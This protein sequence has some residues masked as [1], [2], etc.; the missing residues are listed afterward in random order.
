LA[1][2]KQLLA[3]VRRGEHR[4]IELLDLTTRKLTG[5]TKETTDHWNPS[6]SPDG[7]Q[8]VYHKATAGLKVPN[9]VVGGPAGDCLPL[10]LA[11]AFRPS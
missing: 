7:A 4:Q 5:L 3:A 1:D 9:V 11:G 8:V 2:G 6:V 10:R